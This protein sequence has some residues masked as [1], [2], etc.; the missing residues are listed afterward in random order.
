MEKGESRVKLMAE[1]GVGC[2]TLYDLKK[3]KDKLLSFVAS[4]EGRTGKVEK[5]KTLKGPQMQDLDRA[6]YLWFQARRSEGKAVSGPPLVDK[7][8]KLKD[9]LGIEG[10]FVFRGL[11]A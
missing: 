7:A 2:S 1:Y 5:R 9:D 11:A 3:Q 6:F 4:I 10:V 8:K